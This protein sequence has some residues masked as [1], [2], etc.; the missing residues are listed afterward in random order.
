[1]RAATVLVAEDDTNIREL[2]R[3]A[4]EQD[5]LSVVTARDGEEAVRLALAL[6]PAAVVLDIG[7]P[8]L[9]GASVAARIR[10]AYDDAV[11]FIVVTATRRA[12]DIAGVRA[13]FYLAKPFE[14]AE[15]VK[16]VRTAIEPQLAGGDPAPAPAT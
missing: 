14:V 16:V 11:P 4:L 9:D 10:E 2:L 3:E 15:L 5:G 7:L 6:P 13:T 8:L 1:L 12:E